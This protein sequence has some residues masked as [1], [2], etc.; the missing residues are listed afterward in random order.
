MTWC[1]AFGSVINEYAL[2]LNK[3]LDINIQNMVLYTGCIL[4]SFIYIAASDPRRVR[5]GPAIFFTGFDNK[6][7]FTVGLQSVTG[8]LVSRM[9]K[10][11]DAIMKTVA[12]CLRGPIIVFIAPIFTKSKI[13][14][15]IAIS[16]CIVASGCIAY[17]TQG[18]LKSQKELDEEIASKKT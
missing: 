10:H 13:G 2:K 17:L 18:P 11:A 15:L 12:T 9:L 7:W 4:C 16:A 5:G 8:L 1:N 14:A 6:T 3:S